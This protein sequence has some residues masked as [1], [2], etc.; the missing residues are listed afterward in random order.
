MLLD[1]FSFEPIEIVIN[2]R[3]DII[4]LDTFLCLCVQLYVSEIALPKS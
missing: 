3:I 1:T 2:M 4:I